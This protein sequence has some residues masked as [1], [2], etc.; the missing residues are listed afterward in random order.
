ML[1]YFEELKRRNVIR[2]IIAYVVLGW[3]LLQVSTNLEEALTLP[4]WFDGLV[5]ALLVIG[6]PVVAVFSWVFELT[7][8]GLLKTEDVPKERSISIRTGRRCRSRGRVRRRLGARHS[9]SR[10]RIRAASSR[11]RPVPISPSP[12]CHSS[13]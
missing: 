1:N 11:H 12:Y 3:I 10:I 8:E 2:A 13:Q 7:P 9:R 6:L 5:A 4:V